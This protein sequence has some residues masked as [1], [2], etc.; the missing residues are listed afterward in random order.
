MILLDAVKIF[1]GGAV[2]AAVEPFVIGPESKLGD[3][4]GLF[5]R[6]DGIE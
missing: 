6:V 2:V 5:D 1:D 4:R 3:N